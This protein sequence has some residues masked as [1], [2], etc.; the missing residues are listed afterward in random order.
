MKRRA[1]IAYLVSAAAAPLL[2]PLAAP[3]QQPIPTVGYL[4]SRSAQTSLYQAEAFR[5]GLRD[6]GYVDGKNVG[7]VV[8]WG[9]GQ[10]DQLP[11]IARDM[12]K[13]PLAVIAA[14]GGEP[15]VMAARAANPAIPLVFGMSSDPI[16]LGLAQSFNRPGGN[17]TGVNIL[18]SS[19]EPKRLG[20]LHELLPQVKSIGALVNTSFPPSAKE[21]SDLKQAA[22]MAGLQLRIFPI[23]EVPEVD[24]AFDAVARDGIGA[25]AVA[26]S[27]FF[28]THRRKLIELAARYRVPTIYHFREYPADGGLMSYGIDIREVHRQVGRY[29]GRILK[30]E[31]PGDLPIMQPT[32]F[33]FVIN[34]KTAMALGLTIPS[35]PLS[36]ADEVIE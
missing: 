4:H 9:D 21:A 3:A 26:G 30:G 35:G 7:V 34:M 8:R 14:V 28:D 12:V 16:K 20:L 33:E 13:Q 25:M 6:L 15:D 23:R 5:N 10:F 11:V 24:A 18:T 32:K 19:L 31:K 1:V 36:I 2:W 27:P 17:V 22:T 29:V